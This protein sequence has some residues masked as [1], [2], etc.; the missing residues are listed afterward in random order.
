MSAVLSRLPALRP[1]HLDLGDRPL[2]L[3]RR[4]LLQ[5]MAG[6]AGPARLLGRR[7]APARY[8]VFRSLADEAAV[9]EWAEYWKEN[10]A[11]VIRFLERE[12]RV[13]EI[14]LPG[15][16]MCDLFPFRSGT[17]EDPEVLNRLSLLAGIPAAQF[18]ERMETSPE[19]IVPTP[20]CTLSVAADPEE[21][22]VYLDGR[23]VGVSPLTLPELPA[24]AFRL[25]LIRPGRV[26][27]EREILVSP[28]PDGRPHTILA[29]LAPE[30][31]MAWILVRTAPSGAAVRLN[32][33]VRT[34]PCR[35]RVPAG[36]ATLT[37]DRPGFVR[38]VEPVEV[39][40]AE[41]GPTN[42]QPIFLRLDDARPRE[43]PAGRLV[44]Y[45]PGTLIASTGQASAA[46]PADAGDP[47]ASI[48][49]F[50]LDPDESRVEPSGDI[51]GQVD[52]HYGVTLLGRPD[53]E[54]PVQ[55]DVRLFDPTNSV[56]RGCHA[57]IWSY[58]DRSTDRTFNSFVLGVVSAKGV[59]LDGRQVAVDETVV[60]P[61]D[62]L[63]QVGRFPIR[64]IKYNREA[65]MEFHGR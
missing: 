22:Q 9:R 29:N 49:D 26:P 14:D 61:D 25:L 23:P 51:L 41:S 31:P 46:V 5:A 15:R 7:Q 3:L 2:R 53:A 45:R 62:A 1:P 38:R 37:A 33:E 52:L 55:P 65:R 4:R 24:G 30:P 56:S 6:C 47:T 13:R 12:A 57:W 11:E 40:P 64:L 18:S 48:R 17:L 32:G 39:S 43:E 42:T 59:N 10:E 27:W 44:I 58:P 50:F 28:Q 19:L 21:A 63:L 60:L 34:S 16:P 8:R 36:R 20:L 35:W 54:D